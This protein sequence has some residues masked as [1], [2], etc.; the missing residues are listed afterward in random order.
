MKGKIKHF[1]LSIDST[2]LNSFFRCEKYFEYKH[3]WH[4]GKIY[5][6]ESTDLVAGRA[7]ADA[8]DV[9]KKAFWEGNMTCTEAIEKGYEAAA[10]SYGDHNPPPAK[11]NKSLDS[12][13]AALDVY[14][15]EWRP[16]TDPCVP[17]ALPDGTRAIEWHFEIPLPIMH[18][19]YGIPLVYCGTL[20]SLVSWMG[21][22]WVMDEKTAGRKASNVQDLFSLRGQFIGYKWAAEKLGQQISGALVRYVVMT[23][24]PDVQEVPI[25]IED[26]QVKK[27]EASMLLAVQRM[28][29]IY[30]EAPA[31]RSYGEG[32]VAYFRKCHLA[33]GCQE[34]HGDELLNSDFDQVIWL[35]SK[36]ERVPLPDY[37]AELNTPEGTQEPEGGIK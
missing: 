13:L 10:E 1:P 6:D 9:T 33:A 7:F 17:L 4:L 12:V 36:R 32:C 14:F 22:A 31:M 3:L 15:T 37:L 5:E 27:W 30:N 20:D 26:A 28:V 29:D 18:P 21:T 24:T 11:A 2:M 8:I 35:P 23:K 34:P 16:D 19:E 25:N